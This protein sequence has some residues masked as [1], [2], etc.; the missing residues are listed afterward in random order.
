MQELI[1]RG[2]PHGTSDNYPTRNADHRSSTVDCS[3]RPEKINWAKGRM[4]TDQYRAVENEGYL[5]T[6]LD[7]HVVA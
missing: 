5:V 4:A 6:T 3:R 7:F 2:E 1:L